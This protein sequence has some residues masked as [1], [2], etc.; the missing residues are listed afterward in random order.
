MVVTLLDYIEDEKIGFVVIAAKYKNQWVLCRHEERQTWEIPGGHREAGESL[1]AAARRE[2]YEET[3]AIKVALHSV[4]V[5]SVAG[6]TRLQGENDISYGMLYAADIERMGEKPESEIEEVSLIDELPHDLNLWTYPEIQPLLTDKVITAESQYYRKEEKQ[7]SHIIENVPFISQLVKYPTG[8]ESVST[9]MALNYL[10]CPI[11]VEELIDNYLPKGPEPAQDAEGVYR[12]ADPWKA[13]PG[14]PYSQDGWGC[15][16]PVVTDVVSKIEGFKATEY[17]D[18]TLNEI[19]TRFID[20]DQPVVF[21]ATI[22]MAPPRKTLA[23]LTDEGRT[24]Q[25]TSPM[26]CLLLIGYDENGYY[27]NDPTAGERAFFSKEQVQISY[28]AQG[29]QAVVI[30]RA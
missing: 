28:E 3:G 14:D 27:F 8:C 9:V 10:G 25:W 11:T 7:M 20:N 4:C 18:L 1:E 16:A 2:L 24:I 12:G 22:N 19:C 15:F 29:K 5:Y 30:E 17:Y 21:W 13:F 6:K 26:H 23:W